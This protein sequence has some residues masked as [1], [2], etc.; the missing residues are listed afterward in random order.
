MYYN[1]CVQANYYFNLLSLASRDAPLP[2]NTAFSVSIDLHN[3]GNSYAPDVKLFLLSNVLSSSC[4]KATG[5]K[6]TCHAPTST[7]TKVSSSY[8]S[9]LWI[10]S[11]EQ[12]SEVYSHNR[13]I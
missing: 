9:S 10:R 7:N 13:T 8:T 3:I 11:L 6:E 4:I 2:E 1:D 12:V 5:S